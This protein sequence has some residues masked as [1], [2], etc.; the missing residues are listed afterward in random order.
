MWYIN[1]YMYIRMCAC[2]VYHKYCNDSQ[3]YTYVYIRVY[4]CIYVYI[5]VYMCVYVCISMS[6]L[7]VQVLYVPVVG[8][9]YIVQC[10]ASWK[11]C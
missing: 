4:T 9:A 11:T 5:C 10:S 8:Y 3:P 2:R 1:T 6:A 7:H